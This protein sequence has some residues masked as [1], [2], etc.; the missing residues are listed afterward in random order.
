[1][2]ATRRAAT[3]GAIVAADF[4][5]AAVLD[6]FGLDFCCGG[7]Q[8]LEEACARR[9]LAPDAVMEQLEALGEKPGT[10]DTPDSTWRAS[11]LITFVVEKHHAYIKRQLPVIGE[12][13]EKLVRVHGGRHPEL[14][15]VASHFKELAD[16]LRLHMRKE[17]QILFPFVSALEAAVNGSGPAPNDLFGTVRNPIRMMEAEHEAAG[18]ELAVIRAL[19]DDYRVPDDAC[20]TYRVCFDE[21]RAF[22]LDLRA[23]VHAENN[24]LFPKAVLLESAVM[25]SARS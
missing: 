22:D 15:G 17:E 8:T 24:I 10:D 9:G 3:L 13:L 18:D 6:G 4:R 16:E 5:A 19:T 11:D 1:M 25:D 2:I 7:R 12:R 14:V 21:L 23:H 20:A